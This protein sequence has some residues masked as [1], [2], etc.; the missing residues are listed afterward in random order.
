MNLDSVRDNDI[1][2][3]VA[4]RP[5]V[6]VER[7]GGG[8]GRDVSSLAPALHNCLLTHTALDTGRVPED[9]FQE[10]PFLSIYLSV[11]S[12]SIKKEK[13]SLLES[14]SAPEFQEQGT[15]FHGG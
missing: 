12:S 7:E 9:H 13:S 4:P 10:K 1:T 6:R 11:F 8:G 15:H 5:H 2:V 3:C 14:G